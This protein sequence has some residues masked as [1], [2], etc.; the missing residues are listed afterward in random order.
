MTLPA[1][2]IFS[3]DTFATRAIARI[4]LLH[5]CGDS[6]VAADVNSTFGER[7]TYWLGPWNAA[8]TSAT[9]YTCPK[10]LHVS[11]F[12]KM[13]LE[14]DFALRPPED[15]FAAHVATMDRGSRLF[16]ATLTL[17]R[18]EWTSANIARALIR[19]PFMTGKVMAAIRGKRFGCTSRA[20][21]FSLVRRCPDNAAPHFSS[22]A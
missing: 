16:D 5:F 13:N 2:P 14:Y 10:M 3:A 20:S 17:E 7:H 21:W 8:V 4:H 22:N 6:I 9:R 12:M 18:Q 11:P 15:R 19:Q 1:G